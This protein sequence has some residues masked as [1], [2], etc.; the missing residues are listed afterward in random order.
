MDSSPGVHGSEKSR[1][2][3][4]QNCLPRQDVCKVSG[5]LGPAL[6]GGRRTDLENEL[7]S[8]SV[9]QIQHFASASSLGELGCVRLRRQGLWLLEG[10]FER[11]LLR[12][13]HLL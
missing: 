12:G 6:G 11:E 9:S 8:G 3:V 10:R 4:L 5:R 13:K 1:L 7:G 2:V